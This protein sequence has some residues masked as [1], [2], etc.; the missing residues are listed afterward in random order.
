MNMLKL[1]E[2]PAINHLYTQFKNSTLPSQERFHHAKELLEQCVSYALIYPESTLKT[3]IQLSTIAHSDRCKQYIHGMYDHF[4]FDAIKLL[5]SRLNINN[6]DIDDI[7]LLR[8]LASIFYM[9]LN[10]E[11]SFMKRNIDRGLETQLRAESD[12][13]NQQ[14]DVHVRDVPKSMDDVST[15]NELLNNP[16]DVQIKTLELEIQALLSKWET[17]IDNEDEITDKEYELSELESIYEFSL[18]SSVKEKI[19]SVKSEC[20]ALKSIDLNTNQ[21]RLDDL[22]LRLKLLLDEVK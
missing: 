19:D 12:A 16:L 1:K 8:R 13:I 9:F 21:I 20:N 18:D 11:L 6:I 3:S 22:Y 7:Q 4:D 2:I 5:H 15:E 17:Y 14:S 10:D